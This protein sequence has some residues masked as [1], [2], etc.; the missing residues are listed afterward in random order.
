METPKK[1]NLQSLYESY[2][3]DP[4]PDNLSTVVS[5]LE[6]S[7]NYAVSSIGAGNDKLVRHKARLIAGEAIKNYD[8]TQG[9][10]LNTWVSNQLMRV[11]RFRR[12]VQQ[13]IKIP[14]R[15]QLEAYALFTKEQEFMQEHDREPDLEELADY[16]K[17]PIKKIEKIRS[18]FKKMPSESAIAEIGGSI[19]SMPDY[20][21]EA[22]EYIYHESDKVDRQ[23]IEMKTGFG[24]KFDPM[25]PKEIATKLNLTPSQL[26]RRSARLAY[27]LQQYESALEDTI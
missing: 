15:M 9:A 21:R 11:K 13:P 1:D 5:A 27:K 8:A 12:E 26:S 7:I 3:S 18:G 16:A 2:A 23:I 14:E 25:Q 22:L 19:H 6:P 10:N 4:T 20:T 24:G 17:I